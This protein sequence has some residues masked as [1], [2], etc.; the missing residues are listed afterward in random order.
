[1]IVDPYGECVVTDRKLLAPALFVVLMV[2]AVGCAGPQ[3]AG[4]DAQKQVQSLE[5]E[6]SEALCR[7]MN[8]QFL[9]YWEDEDMVRGACSFGGVMAATFSGAEGDEKVAIC[10]EV[11]NECIEE[12]ELDPM[13]LDEGEMCLTEEERLQCNASVEELT[14]CYDAALDWGFEPVRELAQYGC[15]V[16]VTDEGT[17]LIE[18]AM[19][20]L[21]Q[22]EHGFPD[23]EECE[24][25][26][27]SC[28]IF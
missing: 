21:D 7:H 25:I 3:I 12:Y 10:D 1:M 22:M 16:L 11:V 19:E 20:N 8:A 13:D 27:D 5:Q 4:I 28:P 24:V 17:R 18:G 14:A 23:V 9:S 6:E 2:F 15:E 26:R